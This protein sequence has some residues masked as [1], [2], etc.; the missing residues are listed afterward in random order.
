MTT[1]PCCDLAFSSLAELCVATKF[2]CRNTVSIA[3][4]FD[5]HRDNFFWSPSVCVATTISCRDL[6]VFPFIEFYVA[7][8]ILCHEI[9]YVVS[10]FDPWSQPLFHVATSFLIFCL[11]AS[12]DLKLLICLF[13]YRDMRIRSRLGHFFSYCNSYH[14]LKSMSRPRKHFATVLSFN[15]IAT[16]FFSHNSFYSIVQLILML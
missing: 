5:S 10:Q 9:I 8:T 4:H 6:V 2:L 16:S 14:D 1:S 12:C 7:T 15:L 11:H 13:S 3:S